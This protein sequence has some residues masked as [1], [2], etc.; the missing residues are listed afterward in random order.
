MITRKVVYTCSVQAQFSPGIVDGT[1]NWICGYR[2]DES[3]GSTV[4]CFTSLCLSFFVYKI[5]IIIVLS[6]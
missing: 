4:S 1:V 3:T 2:T 6:S 5:G